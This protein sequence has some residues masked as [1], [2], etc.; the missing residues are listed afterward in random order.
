MAFS[1]G[2]MVGM[3]LKLFLEVVTLP[4]AEQMQ[5]VCPVIPEWRSMKNS[6][7]FQTS[8]SNEI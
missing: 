3:N 7:L 8:F 6:I 5:E 4:P 2:Y 1:E